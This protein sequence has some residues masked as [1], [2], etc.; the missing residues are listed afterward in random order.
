MKVASNGRRKSGLHPWI[1]CA[2]LSCADPTTASE[3]SHA[4]SLTTP[5][6]T[7]AQSLDEAF[8]SIRIGT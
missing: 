3:G 8:L 1:L 6:T 5:K 7:V 4:Q 2:V